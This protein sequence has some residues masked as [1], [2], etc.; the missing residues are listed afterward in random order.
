M[1]AW[2]AIPACF[3][4][5]FVPPSL[6]PLRIPHAPFA[7]WWIV[8][9]IIDASKDEPERGPTRHQAQSHSQF[10]RSNGLGEARHLVLLPGRLRT[11]PTT[12]TQT[13]TQY[14]RSSRAVQP[15]LPDLPCLKHGVG[16]APKLA[17]VARSVSTWNCR[18]GI[19]PNVPSVGWS[20]HKW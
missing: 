16:S 15:L 10:C 19:R 4:L 18:N 11:S 5:L 6:P 9:F 2:F 1:D 20:L 8:R 13:A 12:R 7:V 17:L 14:G 3:G